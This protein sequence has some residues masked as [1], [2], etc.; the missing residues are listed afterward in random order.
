[1]MIKYCS[2]TNKQTVELDDSFVVVYQEKVDGSNIGIEIIDGKPAHL[3][4]RNNV[5]EWEWNG[6]STVFDINLLKDFPYKNCVIFGE[7]FSSKIL[8]R[9]PYGNT[10]VVFYD[11][12]IGSHFAPY[13]DAVKAFET[14]NIPYI[15]YVETTIKQA[16]D[17]DV[18]NY[19]S[20]Y[21][22]AI[23]EGIVIKRPDGMDISSEG[24]AIKVK[25][26]SFTQIA[27]QKRAPAIDEIISRYL[28]YINEDRLLSYISKEGEM[29]TT[30]SVPTYIKGIIDDVIEEEKVPEDE[31]NLFKKQ[32]SREVVRLLKERYKF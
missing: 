30:K 28:V 1:M 13:K 23:A 3:Q 5:V 7:I 19:K 26:D 4:S 10:R 18:D 27:K 32:A 11:I 2:L 31:L 29:E 6:F 14:N 22:D 21:A 20:Q 25:G 9:I 24:Y 16:L 12:L 15:P 8:R 17:I